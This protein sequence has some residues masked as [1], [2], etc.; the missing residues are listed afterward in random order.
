MNHT[1]QGG[2]SSEQAF[3]GEIR[4]ARQINSQLSQPGFVPGSRDVGHMD[5]TAR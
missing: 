3:R 2:L 4:I 5:L 1:K